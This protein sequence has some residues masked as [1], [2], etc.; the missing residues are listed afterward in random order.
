M[1]VVFL[2]TLAMTLFGPITVESRADE[3]IAERLANNSRSKG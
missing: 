1:D 2:E 3:M